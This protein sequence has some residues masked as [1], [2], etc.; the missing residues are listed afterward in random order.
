MHES[1]EANTTPD[2]SNELN[3]ASDVQRMALRDLVSLSEQ[4]AATE[5]EIDRLHQTQLKQAEKQLQTSLEEIQQAH[6]ARAQEVQDEYSRRLAQNAEQLG[7]SMAELDALDKSVRSRLDYEAETIGND[8]KSK[9]Q[10]A[11]WLAESVYEATQNQIA[12]EYKKAKEDQGNRTT[13]LEEMEK[14]ALSLLSLYSSKDLANYS[15]P[16]EET[17]SEGDAKVTVDALAKAAEPQ[18]PAAPP[19]PYPQ[20]RDSIKQRLAELDRLQVPRLFVGFRP[21]ILVTVI[22]ILPAFITQWVTGGMPFDVGTFEPKWKAVGYSLGASVLFCIIAGIVL[23]IVGK[24][25]VRKLYLPIRESLEDARRSSQAI[26][27]DARAR[28]E[29]AITHATKKRDMEIAG[30]KEKVAP[31][32]ARAEKNRHTASQNQ[33][34]DFDRRLAKIHEK[35]DSVQTETEQWKQQ[36]EAQVE[37]SRQL[38][39]TAA[40][41]RHDESI[42]QSNQ[43]YEHNRV[44]LKQRWNDGLARIQ[45]PIERDSQSN[46]DQTL[47]NWDDPQWKQWSPPRKFPARVRFGE[48]LVDLKLITERYPRQ[49]ELPP[50]FSVPATLSFPHQASL[51]IHTDHAGRAEAIR[52]QQMVMARLLTQLPPGRVRFTIIDP[53]A[54]GQNFAGFM[55]L[56]DHDEALVGTRI[57]TE[58][59]HIEQ[60]LVNLTEHMET[61]IQKYLRNE[62]ATIDEYNAQAGELAEP[63]RFLVIADFPVRFEGDAFRRLSSIATSGARCG[64]FTLIVRDTRQPLPSGAH[65]DELEAHSINLVR[66]GDGFMWKDDIFKQFPLVLDAP[67]SEEFLTDILDVVGK[68][69]KEAKRVEVAFSA[70]APPDKELWSGDSQSELVVPIGRLGATR[71]QLMKLG[72]GVAQHALIA[73]KTGSGKSTLLHVVVTN[74]ALWYG[75]DQ[76]EF[77]LVD[78]KKGVEFKTYATHALPHARAIA[79]ESDREF[80]LSVLQRIDAELSRRGEIFRKLGVQDLAGYRQTSDQPLPRTLLMID[81]FQEFFSEDDKIAQES[82]LLLDRLVRQG[83]AFGIHVLLGSQTIGGTSGLARSTIGQMAVRI[84]LQTSEIDS[85]LILGDNNSAARLLSRPGEA[86]YNDAGGLVE[87]NS[88]FQISWLPDE[89]REVWL[90]RVRELSRQK[91]T[92]HAEPVVFEGNAPAD[93]G[94]NKQLARLIDSETVNRPDAPLVWLG[95]PVAIKEPTAITLRPQSGSNILIVG[96]QEESAMALICSAMISLAAQHPHGSAKFYLLDGTPADSSLAGTLPRMAAALPFEVQNIEWRNIPQAISEIAAEVQSRLGDERTDRPFIYFFVYGLQRYRMLR[97]SEESFSFSADDANKAPATDKQFSDILREGPAMGVH[98]I[99]WVD[100]SASLERTMD[101]GTMREFDH[102]VLFQMSAADS[103]NLI[104]SPL[105]NKLGFHR[106]LAFSEEQGVTEKFRPYALPSKDWMAHVQQ[107]LKLRK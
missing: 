7:Q 83:R 29:K 67:P 81:E 94:K 47:L 31:F 103:S 14:Q 53:V 24:S 86:I 97:K 26:L 43:Q 82:A 21:L 33:K 91:P 4:S 11:V 85:Q 36:S 49:L 70:I 78:F 20:T 58:S 28:R 40:Q 37:Q 30:A 93:I 106:A 52:I 57:W 84:A 71:L 5:L 50:T 75:P 69:A 34:I 17:A 100:T 27:A 35:R 96:Q 66:K 62:F 41:T 74:L 87:G 99:T 8:I 79:V 16:A 48:L 107:S 12:K 60:Q 64:V 104:D 65:M 42:A 55:H 88:P 59:E 95:D 61:V 46:D 105:A 18:A 23:R 9:L 54:L 2:I 44:E 102:R 6:D 73:G 68:K 39:T 51:L 92:R 90:D 10:Q 80:G 77:Y 72:R 19:P 101:R 15:P 63:Y 1:A 32:H 45:T 13:E 56:A 89:D 25:Q 3:A 22:C 38:A 98:V 76:V